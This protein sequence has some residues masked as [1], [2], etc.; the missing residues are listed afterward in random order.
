[1][2]EERRPR[3]C[4][5]P[6]S[7]LSHDYTDC[8]AGRSRDWIGRYAAH[9]VIRLIYNETAAIIG[10]RLRIVKMRETKHSMDVIPYKITVKGIELKV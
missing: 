9:G 7:A 6:H 4:G 1:M 5:S 8:R 3:A 10:R 2:S